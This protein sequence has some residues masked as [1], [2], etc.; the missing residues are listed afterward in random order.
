MSKLIGVSFLVAGGGIMAY[1]FLR[2]KQK[3]LSLSDIDGYLEF[4]EKGIAKNDTN[5]VNCIFLQEE[6]KKCTESLTKIKTE[7]AKPK[8]LKS[9]VEEKPS[10]ENRKF[11]I[12]KIMSLKGCMTYGN[13]D[14]CAVIRQKIQDLKQKIAGETNCGQNTTCATFKKILAEY[15]AAF[16][17]GNCQASF[18]KYSP[19][20][21]SECAKLD[22]YMVG[23]ADRN[24]KILASESNT[25]NKRNTIDVSKE[26]RFVELGCRDKLEYQRQKIAASQFS[27]EAESA[28]T[29]VLGKS[30]TEQYVYIGVGSLVLLAGLAIVIRK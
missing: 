13:V 18:D 30:D 15:E 3:P 17:S 11:R 10:I 16:S 9:I 20:E 7:E 29:D 28:E 25:I 14:K 5:T 2:K 23:N 24:A 27:K 1:A 8:P 12:E 26:M 19:K 4:L 21:V 22:E 6:L